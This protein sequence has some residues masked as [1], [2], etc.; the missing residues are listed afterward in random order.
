MGRERWMNWATSESVSQ[1][2]YK[3]EWLKE[4]KEK[5]SNYLLL[6]W[7]PVS[8]TCYTFFSP[9]PF[10]ENV[11]V[12]FATPR[13]HVRHLWQTGTGIVLAANLR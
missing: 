3:L 7:F 11:K 2:G 8:P 12:Q 5:K 10:T 1:Q 6:D 9:F 4:K 13:K